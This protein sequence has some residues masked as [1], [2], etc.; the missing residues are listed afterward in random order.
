MKEN[1]DEVLIDLLIKKASYGLTDIEQAELDKLENAG[2]DNSFDLTVS[3][4]SLI[5]ERAEDTMP[6]HLRANI[7]ASAERYFDEKEAASTEQ[8]EPEI[9]PVGAALQIKPSSS[10]WLGWA[11]AAAACLALV[12]NVYY[13]ST[14]P[15]II[16]G[17]FPTPS[18]TVEQLTLAQQREQLL[19][20]AGDVVTGTW[21]DFDPKKPKNV[22]G[23]VVWS[24]SLQKGFI[25]FH[26]LPVNDRS[27][28][29]YQLWIFD[30]N[31]SP[32]TPVD[33]GVFDAEN[34]EFIVPI[35]AKL[36]IQ[37]PTMFAVT[38]E[39]PGGVVVSDLGKV[40]A[41]AKV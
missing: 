3:A 19:A 1:T 38:A 40:M 39:K 27:K 29:T 37:K 12:A 35:G 17:S 23:D 5:N 30:A 20:T 41:V 34:G 4:I 14:H 36:K 22:Q 9:K 2:H 18:P 24:N 6:S 15:K 16:V 8:G 11:V 21:S 31:Q 32:K 28:E 10:N 33:G 7:R 13:T 25:R 26:V